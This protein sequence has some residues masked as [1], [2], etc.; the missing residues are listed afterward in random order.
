MHQKHYSEV[1]MPFGDGVHTFAL[2]FGL[3]SDWERAHN[4]SLFGLLHT[5]VATKVARAEDVRSIIH[6]GLVG[7][8]KSPVEAA[9]I[10]RRWVENRPL[11]ESIPVAVA[12]LE[13]A[14]LGTD[15]FHA[16]KVGGLEQV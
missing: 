3:V 13:A 12:V 8:G 15:E 10:V 4:A 2:S 14:F 7:G 11:A 1:S 16:Q 6:L 5:V 9:E